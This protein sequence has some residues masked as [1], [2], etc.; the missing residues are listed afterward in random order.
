MA[1]VLTVIKLP[2]YRLYVKIFLLL[3]FT[4]DLNCFDFKLHR[5][6]I[7]DKWARKRL[8]HGCSKQNRLPQKYS[9]HETQLQ[10]IHMRTWYK[11]RL[12]DYSMLYLYIHTNRQNCAQRNL[13]SGSFTERPVLSQKVHLYIFCR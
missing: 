10:G 9:L 13:Y 3:Q 11:H 8:S 5:N 12:T 1:Q 2:S 4:C 7:K 6:W